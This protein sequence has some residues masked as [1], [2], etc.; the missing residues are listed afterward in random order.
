MGV[1]NKKNSISSTGRRGDGQTIFCKIFSDSVSRHL[2]DI[3]RKELNAQGTFS[4]EGCASIQ[5]NTSR[6]SN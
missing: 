6:K 3:R 4:C 1:A 5:E 2:C